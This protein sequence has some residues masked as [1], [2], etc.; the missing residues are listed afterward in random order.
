MEAFGRHLGGPDASGPLFWTWLHH[1][2]QPSPRALGQPISP[3]LPKS[4][5]ESRRTLWGYCRFGRAAGYLRAIG[6][7]A[8]KYA[9][10][11]G[12]EAHNRTFGGVGALIKKNRSDQAQRKRVEQALCRFPCPTRRARQTDVYMTYQFVQ[13][14]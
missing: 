4:I 12:G 11:Q 6:L 1:S 8:A 7:A 5:V 2:T 14:E 10:K 3:T 9:A 13:P